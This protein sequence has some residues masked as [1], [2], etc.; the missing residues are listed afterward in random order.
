VKNGDSPPRPVLRWAGSKRQT[1]DRL[2]KLWGFGYARY[3]EPFAGSAA[4][5]F[6]IRPASGLLADKNA[7]LIETYRV[8][9]ECPL[10]LHEAVASIPR[11]KETY[12]SLRSTSLD[13]HDSPLGL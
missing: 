10:K 12:Y 4:L 5:F 7:E 6:A 11:N 9:R 2:K 13:F 1:V 8:L 3:V